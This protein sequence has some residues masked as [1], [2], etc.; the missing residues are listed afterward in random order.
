[1]PSVYLARQFLVLWPTQPAVMSAL[2]QLIF[3][4]VTLK[5]PNACQKKS[6]QKQTAE[7]GYG[8]MLTKRQ[9]VKIIRENDVIGLSLSIAHQ[10]LVSLIKVQCSER[11]RTLRRLDMCHTS[12]ISE[13][14]STVNL[15]H[16]TCFVYAT[17]KTK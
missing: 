13:W 2:A 17:L 8:S 14:R 6:P 1:M 15:A 16:A 11:R 12:T 5:V 10:T 3:S 9:P 4:S 7:N